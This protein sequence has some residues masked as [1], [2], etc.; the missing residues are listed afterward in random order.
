MFVSEVRKLKMLFA[1]GDVAALAGSFV[2]ALAIHDPS[3]SMRER[4]WGNPTD[5]ILG[6]AVAAVIWIL[7]FRVLDLYRPR[8]GD[9]E[10][11][12]SIAKGSAVAALITIAIGFL[13]RLD[14]S[15]ETVVLAYAL[16]I[17]WVF[18]VRNLLRFG[19]K[20]FYAKKEVAIPLVIVGLNRVGRYLCDQVLDENTH[21][22]LVGFIDDAGDGFSYRG[23]PSYGSI[24]RMSELATEHPCMEVLI[25][26]PEASAE[27][28]SAL[29]RKCEEL[30]LRWSIVPSLYGSM[31]SSLRVDSMGVIPVLGPRGS[32]IEGLNYFVK[33]SFDLILGSLLLLIAAPIMTLSALAI[34]LT[35]GRPVLFHQ[36][37]VGIHAKPFELLKFRTMRPGGNDGAHRDYVRDWIRSGRDASQTSSDGETVFKLTDDNR[38]TSV[39]RW[40]RRFSIDELPQLVNVIRGEMS[41]IG[42]RPA[43][44]YELEHY[45]PIHR[46]RLDALPGLTG[47][48]Q[49]SGR[50]RLSFDDMVRLDLQY[51]E[52]WSLKTDIKIV[53][54]TIPE[55]LR[56]SGL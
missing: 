51:L 52:N 49:V 40:L 18:A 41:L 35:E 34:L 50:S 5:V 39:G 7:A 46:R 9:I 13:T 23:L 55:L 42:P 22:N 3:G 1:I 12:T 44:P 27:L 6:W 15:R 19:V 48:W 21:Y 26:L 45:E 32:N 24:E 56:G 38:I 36:I 17:G 20:R 54:R 47:L 29:I 43:I 25:A 53:V 16:S 4:M 28:Q 31:A 8:G 30:R 14:L 33:R 11:L 2:C 10:E 37:R